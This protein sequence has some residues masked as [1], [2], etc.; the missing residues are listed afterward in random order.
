MQEN[1]ATRAA[2]SS[3]H[4]ILELRDRL[5]LCAGFNL[6]GV[7]GMPVVFIQCL[8]CTLAAV[9]DYCVEACRIMV[10]AGVQQ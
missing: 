9:S 4:G 6:F 2:E 3:P 7:Q 5:C 8:D 10:S 1:T